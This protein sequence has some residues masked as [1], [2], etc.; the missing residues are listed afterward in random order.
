M[1]Q[2]VQN[3][4][5]NM[6]ELALRVGRIERALHLD[7]EPQPLATFARQHAPSPDYTIERC[8]CDESVMLRARV[9]ELEDAVTA[10]GVK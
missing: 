2:I 8:S 5:G 3:L 7:V 6:L 4:Q 9:R 1:Q 10:L